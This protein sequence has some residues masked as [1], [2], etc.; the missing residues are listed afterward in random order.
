MEII[1]YLIVLAVVLFINH[2]IARM[3]FD[4]AERKGHHE[5]KYY[6]LSFW[7][8]AVGYIMVAAL[9]DLFARSQKEVQNIENENTKTTETKTEE[10]KE[11]SNLLDIFKTDN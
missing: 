10:I 9:P 6:W 7:L 3:F 2:L 4:I 11:K 8:G 1:I 5:K